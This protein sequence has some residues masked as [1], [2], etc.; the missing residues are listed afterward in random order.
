MCGIILIETNDN[1]KQAMEEKEMTNYDVYAIRFDNR[2]FEEGQEVP[3]SF[4]WEDGQITNEELDG[5]CGL[6]IENIEEAEKHL[7]ASY[8]GKHVYIIGGNWG[9]EWGQDDNEI[10]ISGA[11]IV[12]KIN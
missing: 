10:I 9:Y 5:V 2:E 7:N 1:N 11:E 4:H 8:E 12:A 6:Y 3:N